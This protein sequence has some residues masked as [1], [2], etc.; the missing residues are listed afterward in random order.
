MPSSASRLPM[1][2]RKLIGTF[3][4]MAWIIAYTVLA[5]TLGTASFFPQHVAVQLVYYVVAGI[6]W[7]FPVRYLLAWMQ[8]PDTP[9]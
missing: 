4:L 5:V 6:A 8:K 9:A 2:L 1:R 3:L 7:I